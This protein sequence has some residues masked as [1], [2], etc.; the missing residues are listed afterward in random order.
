M[1]LFF[2]VMW[3]T[4]TPAVC[5]VLAAL[6]LVMEFVNGPPTV[7]GVK[8]GPLWRAIGMFV[9]LS[10]LALVAFGAKYPECFETFV[11]GVRRRRGVAEGGGVAK[12]DLG[13]LELPDVP[14]S[15]PIARRPS[16]GGGGETKAGD[17][18]LD[19]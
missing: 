6:G 18:H 8:A 16:G 5:V 19:E 15:N 7:E 11:Q 17:A 10:P 4:V 2:K 14:V 3:R 1:P 13:G 12:P 9:M